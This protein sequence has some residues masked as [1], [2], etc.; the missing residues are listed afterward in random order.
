MLGLF[1]NLRKN[2][3]AIL[4]QIM[5]VGFMTQD[6]E[7]LFVTQDGNDFFITQDQ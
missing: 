5:S 2:V 4:Q 7:H 6:S 1:N 3:G